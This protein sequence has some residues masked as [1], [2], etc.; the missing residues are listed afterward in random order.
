M[1]K[2]KSMRLATVLLVVAILTTGIM[3]GTFAKYITGDSSNDSAR[4]AKFGVAVSMNGSLYGDEYSAN[5]ENPA[6]TIVA[7][8]DANNLTSTVQADAQG[9]D[10]VAP[11]TKSDKGFGF[12]ITGTPEVDVSLTALIETKNIFL[13]AGNYAVMVPA[14]GVTELNFDDGTYY[15]LSSGT[16]TEAPTF[17]SSVTEYYKAVN[18]VAV[19]ADYFP[20]VYSL[21]GSTTSYSAGSVAAN[22]LDAVAAL[23]AQKLNG[24]A[25]TNTAAAATTAYAS[26]YQITA[27]ANKIYPANTDLSTA[28]A[29]GTNTVA[30]AWDFDN[31]GAGT[32]DAKDT[33]LG[34]LIAEND[35]A[36]VVKAGAAG[37]YVLPVDG[38]DYNLTTNFNMTVTVTQV[39]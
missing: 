7:Y 28:L 24:A 16:Y 39:D 38:T 23:V 26:K 29:L 14:Q 21:T 22:S 20:V 4:V 33:I 17:S 13:K 35:D 15:T 5:T 3:Y 34:D 36:V 32:H 31:S 18:V 25:V 37:T 2:N 1:K 19:A 12:S 30:W 6:D 9:T 8:S 11:G 27:A 10:V